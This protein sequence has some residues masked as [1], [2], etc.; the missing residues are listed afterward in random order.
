M[1]VDNSSKLY[2]DSID[3][4]PSD[5]NFSNKELVES[6]LRVVSLNDYL[7]REVQKL[8]NAADTKEQKEVV[9]YIQK[10]WEDTKDSDNLNEAF[11]SILSLSKLLEISEQEIRDKLNK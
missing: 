1:K 9:E 5:K 7:K 10:R 4:P 2:N 11:V 3:N 8:W 6:L